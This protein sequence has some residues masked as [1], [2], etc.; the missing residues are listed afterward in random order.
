M[1]IELSDIMFTNGADVVPP[2]GVEKIFNT[3]LAN[4]LAGDDTINGETGDNLSSPSAKLS[5]ISGGVTRKLKPLER[6]DESL[7]SQKKMGRL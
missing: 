5:G 4:T 2:S 3:S 1:A 6:K 7:S